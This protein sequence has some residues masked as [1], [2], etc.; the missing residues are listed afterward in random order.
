LLRC[1]CERNESAGTQSARRKSGENREAIKDRRT[2][3]AAKVVI[4]KPVANPCMVRATIS[5]AAEPAIMKR[6]MAK[7]F[8]ARAARIAGRRPM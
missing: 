8:N 2:F 1:R 6:T 5:A 4:A 3:S 7:T